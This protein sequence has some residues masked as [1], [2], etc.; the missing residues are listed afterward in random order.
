MQVTTTN[1]DLFPHISTNGSTPPSVNIAMA[2]PTEKMVSPSSVSPEGVSSSYMF[3][4]FLE[5]DYSLSISPP[6]L[7]ADLYINAL[8]QKV[9]IAGVDLNPEHPTAKI[10]GSALGFNTEVKLTFD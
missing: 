3:F 9:R 4:G 5:V 2:F 7:K 1:T 6:E 8:G 10:G